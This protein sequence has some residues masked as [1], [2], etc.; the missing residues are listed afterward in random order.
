[1]K[2]ILA[3]DVGGTKLVYAIVNEKGEFLSEVKRT[4]T[5]KKI[6]ELTNLFKEIIS[7]K[8][9]EIDMTAFATAGA[10]NLENTAVKSS[11]PNMPEGY[12]ELDFSTLSN[13]PVFVENDAN[14]A[15][16]AEYKIGAAIGN[17]NTI[18]ITLGT[19]VGGGI[20]IDGKLL[21]GKSGKAGEI[22]SIKINSGKGRECTCHR[23]DCYESYASGT[24]LR[25]TAIET[26]KISPL[27]KNSI[28][29]KKLPD[30]I[31]TYDI[32]EGIKNN[33]EYSKEVFKIWQNDI[34]TGLIGL[35]NIFDT[36]SI[37]ISGGLGEYVDIK[38]MQ[39]IIN[40]EIVVSPIEVKLAKAGNYA[41]M[42]GCALLAT[43]KY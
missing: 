21:R 16:W 5:P 33:D 43:E 30:N 28:H 41:G 42:L 7:S 24:G 31:T 1:M 22:G 4:S 13:K 15:A 18:I 6:D 2:K 17:K 29:S 34:I 12:N 26:A 25:T 23:K 35:V 38:E 36:E 32:I 8:E 19:G 9:N 39:N 27:F 3:I 20:I 40:S 37:V 11:T 14:A 10:V